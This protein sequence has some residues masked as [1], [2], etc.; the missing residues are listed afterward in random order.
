[1]NFPNTQVLSHK[2]YIDGGAR[3]I[4]VTLIGAA[5]PKDSL[6]LAMLTKLDSV[7]LGGTVL[8]IKQGFSLENKNVNAES[9]FEEFYSVVQRELSNR[10]M[11]IDSLQ[12][13]LDDM[14]SYDE[15]SL[16]VAPE[17]KVLFPSIQDLALSRMVAAS[18]S[19]NN[20]DTVNMVFVN[21]PKGLSADERK[22]L[23]DYLG[24]RLKEKAFT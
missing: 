3:H 8:T 15:E 16:A 11:V 4:D 9:S 12:S 17:V 10:Q 23:A 19:H 7:G 14:Q 6:Q 5:L 1:M 21:A 2:E 20:V 22:K 24:L 13:V 18:T